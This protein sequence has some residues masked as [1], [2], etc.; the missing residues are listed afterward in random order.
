MSEP[1]FHLLAR[2]EMDEPPVSGCESS[3]R[4]CAVTL[5]R[6]KNEKNYFFLSILTAQSWVSFAHLPLHGVFKGH[7]RKI[8]FVN[9]LCCLVFCVCC[10]KP[11]YY[12]LWHKLQVLLL[13]FSNAKDL[14]YIA[15]MNV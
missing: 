1:F 3:Y 5:G 13:A 4:S 7:A 8:I 2:Y 15:I 9:F 6:T 14:S 11:F 10:M 12:K